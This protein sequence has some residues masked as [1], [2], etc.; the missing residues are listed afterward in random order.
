MPTFARNATHAAVDRR[1]EIARAADVEKALLLP[2]EG[3]V[4]EILD[5]GA[6]A[7]GRVRLVRSETLRDGRVGGLRRAG[8]RERRPL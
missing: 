6:P 7:D 2:R 3:R 5:S 1:I 4:R 8:V